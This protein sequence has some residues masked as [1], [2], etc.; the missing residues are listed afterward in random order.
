MPRARNPAQPEPSGGGWYKIKG[1]DK[2]I[3][4]RAAAY[5]AAGLDPADYQAVSDVNQQKQRKTKIAARRL[6]VARL[7]HDKY[8]TREIATD[9]G[10]GEGTVSSDLAALRE[11]WRQEHAGTINDRT[12][13]LLEDWRADEHLLR[14]ELDQTTNPDLKLRI[15]DRIYRLQS[16]RAE[17][18]GLDAPTVIRALTATDEDDREQA[19]FVTAD[20]ASSFVGTIQQAAG[21]S[22]DG[23]PVLRVVGDT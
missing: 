20:T 15:I 4:G 5:K 17:L 22:K 11:E 2:K 3:Q 16:R 21:L 7:T 10:I 9:L 13:E 23:T 19:L 6:A 8:T 12:I 18:L 1:R 14:H